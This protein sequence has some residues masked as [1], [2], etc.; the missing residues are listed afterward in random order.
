VGK[1]GK[2]DIFE[3]SLFG[4]RLDITCKEKRQRIMRRK[5]NEKRLCGS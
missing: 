5:S 3:V 4:E 2:L 1:M